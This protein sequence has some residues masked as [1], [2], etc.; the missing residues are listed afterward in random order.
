MNSTIKTDERLDKNLITDTKDKVKEFMNITPNP[1]GKGNG[2][3]SK[4]LPKSPSKRIEGIV[5]N[6]NIKI[7]KQ[8]NE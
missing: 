1:K 8:I 6:I 3:A 5:P 4:K 2:H 7:K